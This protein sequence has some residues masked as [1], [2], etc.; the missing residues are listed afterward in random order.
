MGEYVININWGGGGSRGSGGNTTTPF[1]LMNPTT[2]AAAAAATTAAAVATTA[3]P[4]TATNPA[5]FPPGFTTADR[6][7]ILANSDAVF[8]RLVNNG[9]IS[10]GQFTLP[11]PMDFLSLS[12]NTFPIVSRDG[13]KIIRNDA[14]KDKDT[15]T[16][17][18]N[19]HYKRLSLYAAAQA[20]R[21]ANTIASTKY[22]YASA[23]ASST[24]ELQAV[25]E[26][27]N[28]MAGFGWGGSV[29]AGTAVGAK[30]GAAGGPVG[31]GVGAGIGATVAIVNK[32]VRTATENKILN[33]KQAINATTSAY[34][35]GVLGDATYGRSRQSIG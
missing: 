7:S 14:T 20:L 4:A 30:I 12:R 31:I 1:F 26:Y 9:G 3:I 2:V 33:Y 17:D 11:T 27:E 8:W 10:Q 24:A 19:N 29:I 18:T 15:Y 5:A 21:L 22:Q 32:A 35:L 28:I 23:I 13:K 34:Q 6:T 25:N 16:E